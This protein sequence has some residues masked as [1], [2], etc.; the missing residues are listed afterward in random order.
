MR[1]RISQTEKLDFPRE[2][3]GRKKMFTHKEN[4][5][6]ILSKGNVLNGLRI[7]PRISSNSKLRTLKP[8]KASIRR[9]ISS[10]EN[11]RLKL[12]G[13]AKR[14]FT[15]FRNGFINKDLRRIFTSGQIK[16]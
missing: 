7:L 9:K 10:T 6:W 5:T 14:R 12:K 4:Q 1:T 11:R 13:N 3:F 8:L 2:T 16:Y 15:A